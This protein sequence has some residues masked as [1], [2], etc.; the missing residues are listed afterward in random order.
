MAKG[1]DE[2]YKF[3]ST[4]LFFHLLQPDSRESGQSNLLGGLQNNSSTVA[5]YFCRTYHGT[6]VVPYSNHPICAELLCM[7]KH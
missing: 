5:K 3:L 4:D 7:R 2:G 6:R 1:E